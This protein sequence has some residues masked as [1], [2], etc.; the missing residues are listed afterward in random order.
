MGK[1]DFYLVT[2]THYFE[3]SL[4]CSGSFYDN[5]MKGEQMCLAENQIINRAL[6]EEISNDPDTQTLLIAGDLSK[7]GEYESHISYIEDLKKLKAKGKRIFL[8]TASPLQQSRRAEQDI[9]R[10]RRF[11]ARHVYGGRDG[12]FLRLYHSP[13]TAERERVPRP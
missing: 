8:I 3:R 2:D 4:G 12:I 7:N 9:D 5:K 1:L 6:F 11:P 10:L 13:V